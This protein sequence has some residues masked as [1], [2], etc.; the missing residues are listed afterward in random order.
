MLL[1][2]PDERDG[3]GALE[4]KLKQIDLHAVQNDMYTYDTVL[5]LPKFK[6]DFDINLNEPLKKVSFDNI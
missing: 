5:A 4:D 6:I 2:L 1:L 3:L